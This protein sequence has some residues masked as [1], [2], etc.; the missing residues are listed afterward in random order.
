MIHQLQNHLC[1]PAS[2]LRILLQLMLLTVCSTTLIYSDEL[3]LQNPS[4]TL[5]DLDKLNLSEEQREN[6]ERFLKHGYPE[7]LEDFEKQ[8]PLIPDEHNGAL[9]VLKMVDAV[10]DLKRIND[11]E[12]KMR[13]S[14]E[15]LKD[16]LTS[17]EWKILNAYIELFNART[18]KHFK[19]LKKH[20]LSIYPKEF[21][22]VPKYKPTS[23][24]SNLRYSL[25][26]PAKLNG[27]LHLKNGN[28]DEF[29]KSINKRITIKN[30]LI[31][32]PEMLPYLINLAISGVIIDDIADCINSN[33]LTLNQIDHILEILNRLNPTIGILHGITGER[34]IVNSGFKKLGDPEQSEYYLKEFRKGGR[35]LFGPKSIVHY[36]YGPNYTEDNLSTDLKFWNHFFVTA[37]NFKNFGKYPEYWETHKKLNT[38]KNTAEESGT[39][40]FNNKSY[41]IPDFEEFIESYPGEISERIAN[42]AK[43]ENA[44]IRCS[45]LFS[46]I[47]TD[48]GIKPAFNLT[49]I[50][51]IKG[52]IQVLNYQESTG[53]PLPENLEDF[54]EDFTSTWPID[55][56]T[57]K[58]LHF[59]K[60]GDQFRI[61]SYGRKHLPAITGEGEAVL[62]K[63][64]RWLDYTFNCFPTK[65]E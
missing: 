51:I 17:T 4:A 11:L 44:P 3:Q 14:D 60:L 23:T 59:E 1:H 65:S 24:L 18:D 61:Y 64:F 12:S 42:S 57:G 39:V 36:Y 49:K 9:V 62:D 32:E 16:R 31:Y 7:D 5:P 10:K 47:L 21:E 38:I 33:D 25:I 34:M 26:N 46:S 41:T 2:T 54:P 40:L 56:Y 37:N 6:L 28:F 43:L 19:Q 30:T 55:P 22:F 58:P 29:L 48:F 35:F 20:S 52:A 45:L 13:Y 27:Y 63:P 53:Q 8:M 50:N 15:P